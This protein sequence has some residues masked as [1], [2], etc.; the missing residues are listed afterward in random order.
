MRL[1][2]TAARDFRGIPSV[3]TL[4]WFEFLPEAD[5]YVSGGAVGGDQ[6]FGEMA[7]QRRP[8][9]DHIIYL[10]ANRRAVNYWWNKY[11]GKRSFSRIHVFECPPDSSYAYRDQQIVNAS[12]ELAAF[13]RYPEADPRSA[14][15][16]TWLTVRLARQR[17]IPIHGRI[18]VPGTAEATW[19]EGTRRAS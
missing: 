5:E 15:S 6:I 12:D 19:Q 13:P 3:A 2:F 8:A 18:L 7:F 9:A 1:G 14:R 17:S 10:P 11:R 4:M 16:G